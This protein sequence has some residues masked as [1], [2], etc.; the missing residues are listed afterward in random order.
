MAIKE[1]YF[2]STPFTCAASSLLTILHHFNPEISLTKEKE[3][4]IWRDT[5]NLPTR[6]SSIYA[7]ANYAKKK[8]LKPQVIVEEKKY[9]FPDYRFYRYTKKDIEHASLN[10]EYHLKES[11]NKNLEVLEKKYRLK[12]LKK[13]LKKTK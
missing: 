8:G 13:T 12:R 6:G 4:E 9:S 10:E 2:Q 7:L 5:A 3:F 11:Y 1:P